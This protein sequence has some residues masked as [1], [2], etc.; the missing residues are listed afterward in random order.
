LASCTVVIDSSDALGERYRL[1]ECIGSGGMGV[2]YRGEQIALGR[3]VAI[4][5]LRPDLSRSPEVVRRFH[6]EARAASR[7][8]H[9][10]SVAVYDYGITPTG[11][12]YLVM[13]YVAGKTLSDYIRDQWP[14]PLGTVVDIGVQILAALEDAHASGVIHADIKTDNVIVETRKDGSVRAKVVDYGLARL[15]DEHVEGACGTP[16]YMAPEVACGGSPSE[17]SDL[18]AVGS[19]LYE[20]LTGVP[21]FVGT[22]AEE[23]L[24]RQVAEP[25]A[26]PS[27]KQSSRSIPPVLEAVVM[28]AL[29]KSP[30]E[31]FATAAE[32]G[33]ALEHARPV[34]VGID[35]R[36]GC[37][38]KLPPRT[39]VCL[40]CGAMRPELAAP[41][42]AAASPTEPA[43]VAAMA[44]VRAARERIGRAIRGGDVGEIADGYLALAGALRDTAGPALAARE[45]EE[46]VNIVTGG[47]GPR[48]RRAPEPLWR[49]LL[50]LAL[51]Y[52]A[53][54]ERYR[55]RAAAAHAHFQAV[56][57][58]STIG[59]VHCVA[60]LSDLRACDLDLPFPDERWQ[61]SPSSAASPE[62]A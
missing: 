60:L 52:D 38:A 44:P 30:G 57:C 20:M 19:T 50:E 2:V 55:A 53:A 13:E 16:E 35:R 15:R 58:R 34:D 31:R 6:V 10:G 59:Q 11:S 22:T 21:P 37:G 26:P 62:D 33:A 28:K 12:P 61:R 41:R 23:I 32:L 45:L 1:L 54:R 24:D 49:V 36:C 51:L 18:Y 43:P 5:M 25:V 40:G 8:F 7:L 46:C 39:L 4:K 27:A 48:M 47:E 42:R 29:A 3:T 9:P 14:V 17:V 56:A